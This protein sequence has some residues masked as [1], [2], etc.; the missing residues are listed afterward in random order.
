MGVIDMQITTS[1]DF[2]KDAIIDHVLKDLGLK[3]RDLEP[4]DDHGWEMFEL[5]CISKERSIKNGT[6]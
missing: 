5:L 1:D 3:L 6:I 2:I 4:L